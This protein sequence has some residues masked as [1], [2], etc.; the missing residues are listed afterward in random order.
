MNTL[1]VTIADGKYTVIQDETGR[2]RALRYGEEWRDC[3]GDNLVYYL[4]TEVDELR[5]WKEEALLVESL[6]DVQAVGKELNLP[7]GAMIPKH[8]LPEIKKLKARIEQLETI[9]SMK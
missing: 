8:I 7:L 6:W 2:L 3:C 4:A 5:R 1:E 9:I